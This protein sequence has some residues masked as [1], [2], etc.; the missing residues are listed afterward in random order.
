MVKRLENFQEDSKNNQREFF[1]E[2]ILNR[3]KGL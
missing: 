1:D 3:K 2:K